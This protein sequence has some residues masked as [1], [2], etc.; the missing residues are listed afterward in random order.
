MKGKVMGRY[1]GTDGFRGESNVVLNS[2]QAYR[3]G[4]FIGWYFTNENRIAGKPEPGRIVIGKDTRRSSYMFE[5]ALIAGLVSSGADAYMLHVT[6]TPSVAYIARLDEF[7]C[8]IMITASH[9]PFYDNGIKL[10]N[11][12]GNKMEDEFIAKVED[13]LDGTFEYGGELMTEVPF[14]L[15]DGIGK[16]VD[17]AA[18]R[19]RYI[20]YLI[21]LG[22]YSFKGKKVG[23][24]CA[25]GTTW[26]IA[27]SVFEALG[28]TVY[29]IGNDPDGLNV[30]LNCGSTHI[31]G[32]QK[33]VV[34][35]GLDVGFAFD[36]DADRCLAVDE[37]GN[38]V[39]GDQI[40]YLYA[41]DLKRREKL[42]TN[43]VATTVMSNF[44]LYR[45]LDRVGIEYVQTKVG[46]KYV[47]DYMADHGNPIGGEQ[48]GHIIFSKYATTGDGLLT[49]IKV[50]QVIL[51]SKQPLS[52]LV[53]DCPMYPQTT[54]NIR[55][56]NKKEVRE[57]PDVIAAVEKVAKKLGTTGRIL[58][59]E[60]GTEPVVRVMVEAPEQKQCEEL[61]SS[62]AEVIR[63][64][65]YEVKV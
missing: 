58:L 64:K 19:N 42:V 17:Y 38:V 32:L 65:G 18:G 13:Y 28:A 2:D 25:N 8:G 3:I 35:K 1:F 29:V 43:T 23:L 15:R 36:G 4:R 30:N 60:S 44:G 10:I 51:S 6:P 11:K 34:E 56:A 61:S 52:E 62:V 12:A 48:S 5:Y 50:M 46:D 41:V 7:D 26:N 9:N 39:N 24:D 40:I 16:T 21:S 14:D 54:I 37:K 31:E 53:K 57:D 45:A 33:L 27:K 55:V 20:G 49:S 22:M 63:A 47:H 59:R